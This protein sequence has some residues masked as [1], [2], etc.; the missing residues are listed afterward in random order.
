MLFHPS[1]R[2]PSSARLHLISALAGAALLFAPGCGGEKPPEEKETLVSHENLQTAYGVALKRAR[3]YELFVPQAVK[4][5]YAGVAALYRALERAEKAHAGLHASLMRS[6]GMEPGPVSYDSVV[7][8]TTMQTL[9]MAISSEELEATSMYPNLARTAELEGFAEGLD[10]FT[11]VKA[12]E[13]RHVELLKEAQ[14]R[15]GRIGTKYFVCPDCGY[16]LTTEAT[17]ECPVSKTPK[18]K[19]EKF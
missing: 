13:E 5:R 2:P 11:M 17:E 6:L 3:M 4:E 16:I 15:N 18:S 19:F 12:A 14:D 7:V 8:G 9:K 1:V 10:Q